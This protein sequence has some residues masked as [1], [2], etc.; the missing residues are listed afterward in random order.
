MQRVGRLCFQSLWFLSHRFFVCLF[1]FSF[2]FLPTK[3]FKRHGFEKTVLSLGLIS[4]EVIRN[5]L[6]DGTAA[7]IQW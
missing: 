5:G 3:G 1:S 7:G 4:A 2:F 6:R